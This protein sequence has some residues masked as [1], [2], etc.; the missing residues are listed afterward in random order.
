MN[1]ILKEIKISQDKLRE[2]IAISLDNS[3]KHLDGVEALVEKDLLDCAVILIGFAIEEF[4]RAVYLRERLQLGKD[5]IEQSIQIGKKAHY[6]KY[7]KAFSLLP[8]KLETIWSFSNP[9][10]H[11]TYFPFFPYK[12]EVISPSTRLKP[13]YLH[14][15][16]KTQTWQ[17]GILA[18][19]EKLKGIVNEIKEYIAKFKF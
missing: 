10:L 18:D 13:I 5:T 14:F 4:G 17:R 3:L 11:M 9:L 6:L 15:D 1:Q 16:E 12:K 19:K 7:E 8:K 2:G